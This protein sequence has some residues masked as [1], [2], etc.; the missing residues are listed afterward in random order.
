MAHKVA[1]SNSA[2]MGEMVVAR[3][4]TRR[5]TVGE[6][7]LLERGLPTDT[8]IQDRIAEDMARW[9][10]LRLQMLQRAVWAVLQEDVARGRIS[11]PPIG[12]KAVG[13]EAE[14]DEWWEQAT[15][16]WES[17]VENWLTVSIP[18]AVE[19]QARRF[20]F[21]VDMRMV[22]EAVLAYSRDTWFPDLIK[23]DG[24]MSI[25]AETRR[26]VWNSVLR[27]QQGELGDRGLPD[28]ANH[29]AQWFGPGRAKRIAITEATRVY[30]EGSKWAWLGAATD[31]RYEQAFGILASRWQT[32]RDDLVCPICAPLNGR[33]VLLNEEFP[34]PGGI[35]PAHPGCRCWITP[36][37]NYN[38]KQH[39]KGAGRRPSKRAIQAMQELTMPERIEQIMNLASRGH[40]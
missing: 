12:A 35:P 23:L 21:Y 14:Q 39:P 38:A 36:I 26:K 2:W 33:Q 4:I 8:Q 31:L 25:V 32:A 3:T 28:L 37:K 24:D 5:P 18:Q 29:I 17:D 1:L 9:L 15:R 20:N 34:V 6:L 40:V 27:W 7:R 16:E 22:N 11:P 30:A 10:G 19:Y 13:S